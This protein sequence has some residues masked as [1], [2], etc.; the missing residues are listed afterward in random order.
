MFNA[1][2]KLD[3]FSALSN[4]NFTID[5]TNKLGDE[6][7]DVKVE[8]DGTKILLTDGFFSSQ[9]F[10]ELEKINSDMYANI[11]YKENDSDWNKPVALKVTPD[12]VLNNLYLK[13]QFFIIYF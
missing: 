12:E 7:T 11:A 5:M 13:F 9:M 8:F 10:L 6:K 4:L 3:S 2:F 1:L